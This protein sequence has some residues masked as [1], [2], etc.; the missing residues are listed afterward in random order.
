M[1]SYSVWGGLWKRLGKEDVLRG[2]GTSVRPQYKVLLQSEYNY[3]LVESLSEHELKMVA[4]SSV[5]MAGGV[6]V[7]GYYAEQSLAFDRLFPRTKQRVRFLEPLRDADLLRTSFLALPAF[8]APVGA[9]F[10]LEPCGSAVEEPRGRRVIVNNCVVVQLEDSRD[11]HTFGTWHTVSTI[12][13]WD[14]A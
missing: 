9:L 12:G 10:F 11:F 14:G 7:L 2:G 4:Q 5:E 3:E 6:L 1:N 8:D 13:A